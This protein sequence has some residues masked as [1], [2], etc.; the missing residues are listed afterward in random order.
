M[1]MREYALLNTYLMLTINVK[2]GATDLFISR[3]IKR[4]LF[5]RVKKSREAE[6]WRQQRAFFN[7]PILR[8]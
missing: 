3:K 2:L 4:A 8:P 1:Y 6:D 5:L 7:A